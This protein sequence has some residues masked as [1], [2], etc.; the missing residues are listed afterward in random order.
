M[1]YQRGIFYIIK[2]VL[3]KQALENI[4]RKGDD[5]SSLI[6]MRNHFKMI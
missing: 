1:R 3:P 2:P 5:T 6:G 4:P